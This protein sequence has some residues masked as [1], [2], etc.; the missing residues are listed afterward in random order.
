MSTERAIP[1]TPEWDALSPHHLARYLFAAALAPGK[2]VLD[3]GC[4]GGYG[5]ALLQAPTAGNAALVLASD[6]DAPTIA[7][8]QKTFPSVT[9]LVDDCHTLHHTPGPF[10][11]IC[12]FENIEHLQHPKQF[13]AAA[14]QRLAPGGTLLVSTPDRAHTP[15][16]KNGKPDNPFHFIEWYRQEL[17][18]LLGRFFAEV[19][20]RVQ[21]ECHALASRVAAVEALRQG[22]AWC[23][24]P[25][26]FLWRKLARTRGRRSWKV[27]EALAAPT[28]ADYPIVEAALA[29][30]WGKSYCHV[31]ICRAPRPA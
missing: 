7:Q 4:G 3:A 30:V 24:P 27:I 14:A 6:I 12:N 20:L 29:P 9:F 1:G 22:L 10:D 26:V 28:V 11:L 2:R 15:P 25:A 13:L 23:D 16:F 5:A 21:V 17:A 8:A 19:D 18:E 31:A